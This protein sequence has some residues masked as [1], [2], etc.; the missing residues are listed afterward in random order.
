MESWHHRVIDER[1]VLKQKIERLEAYLDHATVSAEAQIQFS[2]LHI[3][4]ATM[5][6]YATVLDTRIGLFKTE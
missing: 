1:D 3:Q 2:L 4:L 5:C 6:A